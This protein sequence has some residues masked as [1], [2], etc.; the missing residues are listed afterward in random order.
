ML[1]KLKSLPLKKVLHSAVQVTLH[2]IYTVT[3][4][5]A[6]FLSYTHKTDA[7]C[8]HSRHLFRRS[9]RGNLPLKQ[10]T[11]WNQP[12]LFDGTTTS[13][14]ANWLWA[15]TST[16]TLFRCP[17]PQTQSTLKPIFQSVAVKSSRFTDILY[18][19]VCVYSL[20]LKRETNCDI[21]DHLAHWGEL[22]TM[23]H[24]TEISFLQNDRIE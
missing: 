2:A 9:F 20:K 18:C 5:P 23:H 21:K 13:H 7:K 17:S 8:T 12:L 10:V 1:D 24:N 15:Y 19:L 16:D 14:L 4:M 3:N 6:V 11:I 22:F